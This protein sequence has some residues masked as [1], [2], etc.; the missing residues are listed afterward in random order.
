[1]DILVRFLEIYM[2]RK[3]RVVLVGEGHGCFKYKNHKKI[4]EN[5]K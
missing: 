5:P 1:V 3:A 2:T 4:D